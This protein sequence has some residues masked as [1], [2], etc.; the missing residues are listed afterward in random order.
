VLKVIN[1]EKS[2]INE[3][4][5][6]LAT[7]SIIR[8][9]P[10]F[11]KL[12]DVKDIDDEMMILIVEYADSGNLA[13][14]IKD[15]HP[16]GVQDTLLFHM[17]YQV[18][19]GIN[20]LH[21]NNVC[22]RSLS[23]VNLMVSDYSLKISKFCDSIETK[24][25]RKIDADFWRKVDIFSLGFILYYLV[26]A[27]YPFKLEN[28]Q[29]SLSVMEIDLL[30]NKNEK[31]ISADLRLLL[32]KLLTHTEDRFTLSEIEKCKWF[33]NEQMKYNKTRNYLSSQ[34]NEFLYDY[35]KF[36]K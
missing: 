17:F 36:E 21:E 2:D 26:F 12:I 10:H 19:S 31:K 27:M 30:I 8:E 29:I 7:Y 14:F 20:F 35:L 22:L 32:V 1:K 3:N 28:K 16:E 25:L 33:T 11:I 23:P 9:N 4:H 5:R 15:N 6:T 34:S 13:Q 24:S 18:F